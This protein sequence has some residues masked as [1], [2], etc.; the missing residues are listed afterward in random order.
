MTKIHFMQGAF[1]VALAVSPAGADRIVNSNEAIILSDDI[2]KRTTEVIHAGGA[3]AQPDAGGAP[4]PRGGNDDNRSGL[5]DGTNPG[6][7]DG[8]DNSPN[9]GTDNPGGLMKN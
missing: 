6:Q 9:Q 3:G 4:P 1:I 5:G 8:R 2:Y 7:G